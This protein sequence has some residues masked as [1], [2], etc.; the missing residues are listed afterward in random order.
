MRPLSLLLILGVSCSSPQYPKIQTSPGQI[1]FCVV[2]DVGNGSLVQRMVAE[3]ME[4]SGCEKL[5]LLGDLIYP[6]GID[7]ETDKILEERFLRPYRKFSS[8]YVVLGNHDYDG[9]AGAWRDLAKINRRII[10]PG[11]YFRERIN[12]IC[13]FFLDTNFRASTEGLFEEETSW[14]KKETSDC[15][16]LVAFTHHPYISSGR[17]H[18]PATEKLKLFFEKFIV[19]KFQFIFSGHEHILSDEGMTG[20][21]RQIISGAGG[22]H[23]LGSFPG[24]T[25]FTLD[26]KDPIK[27][28]VELRR[29]WP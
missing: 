16:Y 14:L 20:G 19:G 4:E 17:R 28:H 23:D 6:H 10:H 13:L 3:S 1:T 8:I 9:N 5:V 15:G 25:V 29:L 7:S 22:K 27:S 11:N 2:G 18:G 21:T 24:Y 26:L 12:H